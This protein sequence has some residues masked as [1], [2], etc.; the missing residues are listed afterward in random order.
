MKIASFV[1]G[2]IGTALGAAALTL[3]IIA[4]NKASR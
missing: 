4:L 1:T 3:S 2:I